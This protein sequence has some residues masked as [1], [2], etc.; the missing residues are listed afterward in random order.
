MDLTTAALVL[1]SGLSLGWWLPQFVRTFR[2]GHAGVSATG[3][4]IYA[5]N[6]GVWTVWAFADRRF[7]LG[8]VDACEALGA[9]MI[10]G[11]LRAWKPLA[12]VAAIVAAAVSIVA[13]G[14]PALVASFGVLMAGIGRLPQLIRSWRGGAARRG[15]DNGMG[16]QFTGKRGV[17]RVGRA[18][19]RDAAHLRRVDR[20]DHVRGHCGAH[21]PHPTRSCRRFNPLEPGPDEVSTLIRAPRMT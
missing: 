19:R 1:A 16:R 18:G 7:V 21:P 4:A 20:A 8:A 9:T 5:V 14:L 6:T 15:V 10:V 12:T 3:W 13:A 2:H 17:G 11:R